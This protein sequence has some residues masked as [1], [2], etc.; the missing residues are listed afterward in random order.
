MLVLRWLRSLARFVLGVVLIAPVVALPLAVLL[1]RGPAGETRVSPHLFPLVLWLF[2]DFAWTC[3]RNSLIFAT[4]R[5]AALARRGGRPG[6]GR[7]SP[8]VLGA[9][10]SARPGGRPCW[11]CRRRF[12]HW[13]W[14]AFWARRVP[15][16]G[17]LPGSTD[18]ATGVSLESWRGLPLWIAWIWSTLPWGVALVALVTAAAVEQLEPSWED[19]ARLTGVGIASGLASALLAAGTAIV[20][21]G[22]RGGICVR[23]GRARVLRSFSGCGARWRF[24]S[25]KQPAGPIRFP[26]RRSGPS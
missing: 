12:S 9:S 7:R 3:A 26:R 1:D 18:G 8:P 17:L 21:A 10:D 19:A 25:W 22:R 20:G 23:A 11:R 13:D 6:L 4:H 5:L 14:W 15:G 16:R 2:D 24:R